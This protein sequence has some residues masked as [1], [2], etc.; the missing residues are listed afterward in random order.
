MQTGG[1][2]TIVSGRFLSEAPFTCADLHTICKL[3]IYEFA[4]GCIIYNWACERNCIYV[5][6]NLHMCK[7]TPCVNIH[8]LGPGV[9]F[10]LHICILYIYVFLVM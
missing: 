6:V 8:L 9:Y 5:K 7:Y 10:L 2:C 3:Y 4:L 1:S